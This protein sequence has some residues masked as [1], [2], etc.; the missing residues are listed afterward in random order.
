MNFKITI[1]KELSKIVTRRASVVPYTIRNNK[2][3]FLLARDKKTSDITD[4]GGG[5]KNH[6][7]SLSA[8]LREFKEESNCI[9]GEEF[10]NNSNHFSI[11]PCFILFNEISILFVY[12]NEIWLDTAKTVF[13]DNKKVYH[14]KCY[15][16]VSDVF[17][18]DEDCL[19]TMVYSE[20]SSMWVKIKNY[21]KIFY[22]ELFLYILKNKN[23]LKYNGYN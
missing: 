3:Y 17:W 13:E 9:F 7:S 15:Q 6:E 19:K 12:V 16:E 4:F 11:Y 1:G 21:Y 18:L 23:F 22:K 20:H 5:V 2:V 14:S 8:C 10:Y